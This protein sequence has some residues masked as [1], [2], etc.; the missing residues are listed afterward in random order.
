VAQLLLPYITVST[1]HLWDISNRIGK[2]FSWLSVRYG[3]NKKRGGMT[4]FGIAEVIVGLWF[5]PV[6]LF[7]IIPLAMTISWYIMIF[8]NILKNRERKD[9]N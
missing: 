9:H 4:M 6:T 3:R 8:L 5:L 2:M 7:V 1:G